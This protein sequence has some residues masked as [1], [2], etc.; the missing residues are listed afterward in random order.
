MKIIKK[1]LNSIDIIIL[2]IIIVSLVFLIRNASQYYILKIAVN[3]TTMIFIVKRLIQKNPIRI[4]QSK[5]DIAVLL[6]VISSLI[7]YITNTYI[8]LSNTIDTILNYEVLF[9]IYILVREI[10]LKNE[11]RINI[12][13]NFIIFLA[14]IFI[15]IGL[16]NLTTNNI[17][18][19]M[20]IN[21]L[22]NGEGRLMSLIGNPNVL[23]VFIS[24]AFFLSLNE[25][26]NTENIKKRIL[27]NTCNT[28]FLIGIILTYSKTIYI[29]LP[30]LLLLYMITLKNKARNIYI[31][32]STFLSF[33]I[34]IIYVFAFQYYNSKELYLE[35]LIITV[36]TI[37]LSVILNVLNEKI[38]KYTKKIN[39]KI[40]IMVII[41][42][43]II[44][45]SWIIAQLNNG[46]EFV[47]FDEETKAYYKAKILN[48]VKPNPKYV[49]TFDMS[50][51]DT[52]ENTKPTLFTINI[53]ERDKKNFEI[54]NTLEEFEQYV[55]VKEIEIETAD[56]TSEIKIEFGTNSKS[57]RLIINNFY[58]NGEEYI[59]EY[60]YLPTKLVEKVKDIS[61]QY[62]TAQER[63]AFISDGLELIKENP[64]TG[65]GGGGWQFKYGEVQDYNYV[66]RDT[67]SYPIQIWLENGII[68]IIALVLIYTIVF[69]TF[70][71]NIINIGIKFALIILMLHCVIDSDMYFVF[72]Q[73]LFFVLLAIFSVIYSK[74]VKKSEKLDYI[75]NFVIIILILVSIILN[76]N[77]KIYNKNIIV[78]ELEG[79]MMDLDIDR[80]KYNEILE[81]LIEEY[82]AVIK[83]E[84]IPYELLDNKYQILQCSITTADGRLDKFLNEYYDFILTYENKWKY[85]ED[86]IIEK[87]DKT[88]DIVISLS[89]LDNTKYDNEI[90]NFLKVIINEFESTKEELTLA[91]N[92]KYKNIEKN[93]NYRMLTNV[94]NNSVEMYNNYLL[95][96]K[97]INCS[98]TNLQEQVLDNNIKILNKKDI[99]IYHTHTTEAYESNEYTE[100]EYKKTLDS[101]YNV[102]NI[103]KF[104]RNE[105]EN[106]GFN[107]YHIKEYNDLEGVNGAY[108]RSRNVVQKYLNDNNNNIEIIF[109]LHRDSNGLPRTEESY[110]NINGEDMANLRFVV[111]VGH[112]NWEENLKWAIK[113]QREANEK[114]PNLFKP[115]LIYNGT[116]NQDISNKALLIEVGL[117]TNT[118]EEAKKSI[119]CFTDLI[120]YTIKFVINNTR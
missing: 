75:F 100:T 6:L 92:S 87:I 5:L 78:E 8:S 50:A 56:N 109:D 68:G 25:T 86:K 47:V 59:L 22:I 49:F 97:I 105:L 31:L 53:I 60:K 85:D 95:G 94:Y 106:R 108:D 79:R 52:K 63:F 96:V 42:I 119:E 89:E 104:F 98:D 61:L 55:G 103:G 72:I 43:V 107:V 88:F 82:Q 111:A 101:R 1:I 3:V 116:Y 4:I 112:D 23:A 58:I 7:P 45:G 35:I 99:L 48:N 11:K 73:A 80:E 93:V 70:N 51:L 19:F 33:I 9:L 39:I 37:L 14:V 2:I 71:K 16:E 91:L 29:L 41:I 117:D 18:P 27:Y 32:Q 65:I 102:L 10:C 57:S 118:I 90:Y 113:I 66:T 84:R 77:P 38:I 110:V 120:N 67:H 81:Q 44:I 34:S 15:L 13:I 21:N 76:A 26:L 17:I 115:I 36:I 28:I 12:I 64:L 114:Y 69:F 24:M 83:Y 40:F 54:K 20:G 46:K 74:G 30:F 62:K